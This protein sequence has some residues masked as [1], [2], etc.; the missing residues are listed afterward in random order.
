VNK[1][2]LE[3]RLKRHRFYHFIEIEPGLITAG[4]PHM[5]PQQDLVMRNLR[6]LE[7]K[8]KRVLDIGCRDGLFSLEAERLGAAEVVGVD[9]DVSTGWTEVVLPYLKSAVRMH[10]MNL[11][12]LTPQTFGK[13]DVIVFAGVLY[14]LRYPVHALRLIKNL[15]N[16]GGTL[17]LETAILPAWERYQMLYCPT[18]ADS[19]YEP[20]SVTF[21]NQNGMRSTL[22]SLGY[23]L[24]SSDRL[25][26]RQIMST[27]GAGARQYLIAAS[28]AAQ[29][30]VPGLMHR[31]LGRFAID[32]GVFMCGA[33]REDPALRAYWDG[34]HEAHTVRDPWTPG[35]QGRQRPPD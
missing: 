3:E 11:Y 29:R 30:I 22:A 23:Q 5:V 1:T 7:L 32:R 4:D 9:N 13:F 16:D 20:T 26:G 10:G 31:L 34:T 35:D 28:L 2:E 24:L 33:G 19:P 21:F 25:Y 6:A 27:K 12:D 15:L 8:G 17:L 18:E 14:H